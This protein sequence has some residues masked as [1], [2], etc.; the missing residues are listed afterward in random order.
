MLHFQYP[1]GMTSR[2]DIH[3]L[4]HALSKTERRYVKLHAGFQQGDKSYMRLF[5]AIAAQPTYNE[6]AL[7]QAL[8]HEP[9]MRNFSMAKQYLYEHIID[10]LKNYGAYKDAESELTDMIEEFKILESKGL[11]RQAERVLNKARRFAENNDAFLRL[12]YIAI[13]EYINAVYSSDELSGVR[14]EKIIERRNYILRQIENYSLISDALFRFRII[15]RKQLYPRTAQE[16][17]KITTIIEPLLSLDEKDLLSRT[18]QGM[19]S[20]AIGEYYNAIGEPD[21]SLQRMEQFLRFEIPKKGTMEMRTQIIAEHA[22]YAQLCIKNSRYEQCERALKAIENSIKT[23]SPK[24]DDVYVQLYAYERW[25]VSSLAL[26]NKRGNCHIAVARIDEQYPILM[27]WLPRFSKQQR[28]AAYYMMAYAYFGIR[29]FTPAL[30]YCNTLL[31]EGEY[32]TDEH[33]FAQILSIM[34]HTELHNTFE[35]DYFIRN[36]TRFLRSRNRL[37]Q[38]ETIILQGLQRYARAETI[39]EKSQIAQSILDALQTTFTVYAERSAV[40]YFM[41]I[42]TWLESKV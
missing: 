35:L 25:F 20:I 2:N 33:A 22:L 23:L 26:E 10:A 19:Y 38:S 37:Y 13:R 9:C 39:E 24:R 11:H 17:Q 6:A 12:Y 4:I 18:A 21:I 31:S 42:R 40:E 16:L 32:L 36:T 8:L 34:I 7:K 30:S 29:N 28:L 14:L 41:D 27:E 15:Q 5:D 1:I 3:E